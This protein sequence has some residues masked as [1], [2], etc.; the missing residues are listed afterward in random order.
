VEDA[1]DTVFVERKEMKGLPLA[2]MCDNGEGERR[3][4]GASFVKLASRFDKK[5]DRVKLTCIGM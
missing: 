2:L 3:R 1:I 5:H 4:Y